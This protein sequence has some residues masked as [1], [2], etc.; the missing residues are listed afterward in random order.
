MNALHALRIDIDGRQ[1]GEFGLG[2]E[3][4]HRL[5]AGCRTSIQHTLARCKAQQAGRKLGRTVLHRYRT[6]GKPG[7]RIDRQGRGQTHRMAGMNQR[8]R[9]DSLPL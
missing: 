4:M 9:L 3:D 6:V 8:L 5:P 1:P 7:Q 2:L